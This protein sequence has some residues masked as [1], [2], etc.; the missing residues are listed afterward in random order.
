MRTNRPSTTLRRFFAGIS[1]SVFQTQ[2]GVVDPPLIDYLSDLLLRFVR[3]SECYRI[4]NLS[5]RPMQEVG[6]MLIEANHRVGEARRKIL[7]HIGDFTLFWS[8]VY[9][10]A[11]REMRGP[12]KL[13][14]FIDYCQHGKR[15]YRIASEIAADTN[16]VPAAILER[17]SHEFEMC[18]FGL[19]EIRREWERRDD[20]EL[21]LLIE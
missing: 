10:E 16:D 17:L 2:L 20:E 13:D 19:R 9:P 3:A 5:G 21:P 14:H 1:E 11:L 7:R 8:G 4:R 12:G 15:S 18:A 6:E